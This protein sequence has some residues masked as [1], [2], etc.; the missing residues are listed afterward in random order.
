M[1]FEC[2]NGQNRLKRIT[3][4]EIGRAIKESREFACIGRKEMS[5]L[6]GISENTYKCYEEGRRSIPYKVFYL[7]QQMLK[8]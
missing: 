5:E 3:N 8:L 1:K 2:P 4:E 6:I 7:L